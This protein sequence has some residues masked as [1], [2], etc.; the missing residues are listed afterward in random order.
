LNFSWDRS[1]SR[2][3]SAMTEVR[4]EVIVAT[5]VL[6][7]ALVAVIGYQYVTYPK[8]TVHFAPKKPVIAGKPENVAPVKKVAPSKEIVE[9]AN[10]VKFAGKV[11]EK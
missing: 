10:R 7:S 2:L 1:V 9:V 11:L 5:A 3:E 8:A 4:N 6:V